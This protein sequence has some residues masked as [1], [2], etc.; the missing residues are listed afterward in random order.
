MKPRK[1]FDFY[2]H[3]YEILRQRSKSPF[4]PYHELYSYLGRRFCLKKIEVKELIKGMEGR[5][6]LKMKKRGIIL[7]VDGPGTGLIPGKRSEKD[8]SG[9]QDNLR[10]CN[11]SP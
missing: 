7:R 11:E 8:A 10:G 4:I 9:K 3:V 5:G 1:D 2:Q 6:Y